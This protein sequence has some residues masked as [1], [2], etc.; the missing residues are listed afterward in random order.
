MQPNYKIKV[1]CLFG[2]VAIR[3]L[4]GVAKNSDWRSA[5][6]RTRAAALRASY[7]AGAVS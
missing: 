5:A 4:R 1:G 7:A 6:L 2:S 3:Y